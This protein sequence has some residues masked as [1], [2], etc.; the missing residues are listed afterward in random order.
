MKKGI[1][2]YIM[3][4]G[5][6]SAHAQYKVVKVNSLSNSPNEVSIAIDPLNP[7]R[8]VAGANLQAVY[9]ST[10]SGKT[11]SE[12]DL[13]SSMGV[14]GDPVLHADNNGNFYFGHLAKN[15]KLMKGAYD[16]LDRII[17]QKSIDGGKT[18]SDGDYAGMDTTKTQDKHWFST[19][20][21]NHLYVTWTEFDKYESKDPDD[22]SR[23]RFSKSRGEG[24]DF[25]P[26]I[27]I[28]DTVGDCVD[29]DNT[30]EGATTA[31]GPDGTVYAVWAGY[32]N[33]YMDRSEDGGITW[34]KDIIIAHQKGGW[35]LP[36]KGLYR[37]NAM[38]F[39]H[40]D[41]NG[42]L[43]LIY[44]DKRNGDIDI[45]F[46]SS[47]DGGKIWTDDK[48]LNHDA[49]KNGADQF[50]PNMCVDP[51]TQN[52]YIIYY[53]GQHSKT[54][55]FTDVYMAFSTDGGATFNNLRLTANSF[56]IPDKAIFFGDYIDIDAVNNIVRPIWTDY[57]NNTTQVKCGLINANDIVNY[58]IAPPKLDVAIKTSVSG[59]NI[60]V[61]TNSAYAQKY[62]VYI[63]YNKVGE[64]KKVGKLN[65]KKGDNEFHFKAA[66]LSYG[67]Y[68]LI[69]KTEVGTITI[70]FTHPFF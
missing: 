19:D 63:Q 54:N 62:K 33:I 64:P 9:Y 58:N 59:K 3:V 6:A 60:Y 48:R 26:A 4:L 39:L 45:W 49:V 52:V 66:K 40:C 22:H 69:L 30:L 28:S 14:Y 20:K 24:V 17:I 35:D 32:E 23:I 16:G 44:G 29:G 41:K 31:I 65:L 53:D 25:T 1:V 37:S 51:V 68:D 43:Y 11:W 47:A 34:G 5:F 10:D 21:Q 27:T 18:F 57:N 15:K 38:P 46:K 55:M 70:P 12:K 56:P 42:K 2:F 61:H 50:T 7:A 13:R 67:S 36:V 8:L